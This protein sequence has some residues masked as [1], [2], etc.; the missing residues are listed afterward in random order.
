MISG[1]IKVLDRYFDR[2]VLRAVARYLS[3]ENMGYRAVYVGPWENGQ[4]KLKRQIEWES[5]VDTVTWQ[6]IGQ[7]ITPALAQ[8]GMWR[9]TFQVS[10]EFRGATGVFVP[11]LPPQVGEHLL[12]QFETLD[13]DGNVTISNETTSIGLADYTAL[14]EFLEYRWPEARADFLGRGVSEN[15]TRGQVIEAL[16][17]SLRLGQPS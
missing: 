15:S 7:Q 13:A 14:V 12:V 8:L 2:V 17:N 10:N 5:A 16:G 3:E 4:A 11:V 6:D 1:L 9:V